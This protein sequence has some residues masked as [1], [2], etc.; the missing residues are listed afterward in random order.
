MFCLFSTD[1][2]IRFLLASAHTRK[3]ERKG[4]ARVLTAQPLGIDAE[5]VT[6][7]ADLSRG[8]H[9][10]SIVGLA[11][12]AV[13]EARDRISSAIKSI[14]YPPPKATN[15]RI[16]LSL[17][18][19]NLRKDGSQYDVPLA[20]AYLI[21]AGHVPVLRE[22]VLLCGELGLDGSVRPARNVLAHARCAKKMGIKNI[23]VPSE[24]TQEALLVRSIDVHPISHLRDLIAH[25]SRESPI[26]PA[27][28]ANA[29]PPIPSGVDFADIRGQESAKRAL[30]IAATGRH[31]VMLYGPPGTG[32]TML[33]R[34]LPT[35][36]PPLAE[37]E[38]LT[39]TA[40]HSAAGELAPGNIV[41]QPPLRAPH[42]TIS[43]SAMVGGGP[44]LRPGEIS[45]A[46]GGVLFMDEFVEFD[47]RTLE[48]LRQP[49]EDKTV[50]IARAKGSLTLPADF[51]LVGAMNPADTLA[52]DDLVVR[53]KMQQQA[54]KLSRP[55]ID[56]IDLWV[57][58]PRLPQ[59][60][61]MGRVDGA[62]SVQL[63]ERV[64]ETHA[65]VLQMRDRSNC[66]EEAEN[67]LG[68][69]VERFSLSPRSFMRTLRVAKTIAVLGGA[70]QI[71]PP[72][73]MEALQYRPRL[74]GLVA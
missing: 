7:E 60:M 17:S 2:R 5:L 58:V 22:R 44:M 63:R 47:A 11:D 71:E 29:S 49:L 36:L 70:E 52:A 66:S 33:A 53:Q 55:I 26:A 41:R 39:A 45:L 13:A 8:L 57:E 42:H 64:V 48:A 50:R 20:L 67:L 15:R 51:M 59:S 73:V 54:K 72:H 56:R 65:R 10:F 18:P 68:D 6:V 4:Y 14:E 37:E 19:A 23:I 3:M 69:A 40:I 32:K 74:S 24:N 43:T 30:L 1:K 25:V 27:A 61:L 38:S 62:G 16:V 46:H 35:I 28:R 34:A 31:N 12:K 21:A 9:A